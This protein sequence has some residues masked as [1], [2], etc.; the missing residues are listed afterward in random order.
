M[1][2]G[3]ESP[4][5]R[6]SRQGRTT[7]SHQLFSLGWKSRLKEGTGRARSPR[8]QTRTGSLDPPPH[9]GSELA[10]HMPGPIS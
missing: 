7:P 10:Y 9:M 1:G 4:S 3:L 6:V 5:R 8:R 2:T